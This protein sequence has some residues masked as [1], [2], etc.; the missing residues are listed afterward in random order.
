MGATASRSSPTV[1]TRLE[2][3]P[4]KGV[5]C[6]PVHRE[7]FPTQVVVT[8]HKASLGYIQHKKM[9]DLNV[10]RLILQLTLRNILKSIMKM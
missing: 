9:L 10:S 2:I 1:C 6:T 4:D 8:S 5:R 7:L 3:R